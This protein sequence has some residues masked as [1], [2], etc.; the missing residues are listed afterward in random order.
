MLLDEPTNHLDFETVE[1][2]GR[3]LQDFK[4]AVIFISHNRTFVNSIATLILEV[5]AGAVRRYGGTYEEYIYQLEQTIQNENYDETKDE[6]WTE[7]HNSKKIYYEE[8]KTERKKLKRLEDEIAELEKEKIKLNR[9]Q[10]KDPTKFPT[11][12]Y[13]RLGEIV[14]EIQTKEWQWLE[15][16]QK[17]ELLNK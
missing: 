4:G 9:K 17:I 10:T 1:A 5:R 14:T 12:S 15:I 7:H 16:Q 2:L 6:K 8:I 3:A 13:A 11:E